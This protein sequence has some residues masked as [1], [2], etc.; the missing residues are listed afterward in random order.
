MK[1]S[2]ILIVEDEKEYRDIYIKWLSKK[3]Y[4]VE[5]AQNEQEALPIIKTKTIALVLLDLRL[6]PLMTSEVGLS[7][8]PKI[9]SHNPLT[10]IIVTS[11]SDT[12][13]TAIESIK[14]GAY[15]FF[16]KGDSLSKL[17]ITIE[18]AFKTYR[19]ESQ[20][21]SSYIELKQKYS[22][23][24]II[25]K[26]KA[27]Q[28]IFSLLKDVADSDTNVL[29][30]GDT[31]TGKDLIAQ[32][33]HYNS[34]RSSFPFISITPA[35]IPQSLLESE[36][37]GY[38]KG[39]FTGADHDRTGK[40]QEADQG[41]IF[42][43]EIGDLP[44]D[45]QVKLLRVMQDKSFERLG[46]NKTIN[47][48]I[49]I[50][51]ATNRDLLKLV[52]DGHFREDLF[53]RI[54]TVIIELPRLR[55]RK[56][57]IPLLSDHFIQQLCEANSKPLKRLSQTVLESFILYDWPGNIRE[58]KN[59]IE[60]A[61]IFSKGDIINI[62][63]IPID[64]ISDTREQEE[65]TQGLREKL[66]HIEKMMVLDK[67]RKAGYNQSKAAR[68]LKISEKNLRDRMKKFQIPSNKQLR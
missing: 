6:P 61:I 23:D 43:D 17:I 46:D 30:L 15:D 68:M 49:R 53:Y 22:F 44:Y 65:K 40:F 24:G 36:L 45:L 38:K 52:K 55:D 21:Y 16:E 4:E 11:G 47:V 42:L 50:L 10:K 31:G 20:I 57:D 26:S 19:L 2:S 3:G 33:I 7:L 13:N 62:D 37:F 54:N 27:M 34:K 35:A 56:E 9:I 1:K 64:V 60:R 5:L 67:L 39:S 28:N 14:R 8:I 41:T 25:G 66:N 59:V 32:T 63:D 48:D 58:L 29:L 51:S 12:E 18:R